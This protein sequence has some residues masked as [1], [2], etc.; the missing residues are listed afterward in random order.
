M[1]SILKLY[2]REAIV[3]EPAGAMSTASLKMIGEESDDDVDDINANDDAH[4]RHV[5]TSPNLI[6][7][8]R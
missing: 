2:N 7:A 5:Y 4:D 6:R 8:L 1:C 3:V